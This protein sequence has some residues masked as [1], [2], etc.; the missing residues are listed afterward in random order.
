MWF[1]QIQ[2]IFKIG[3]KGLTKNIN[4]HKKK[5]NYWQILQQKKN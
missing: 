1:K 4:Q 3:I 5:M 2:R